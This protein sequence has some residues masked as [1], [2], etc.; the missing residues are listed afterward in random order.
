M[1]YEKAAV[2]FLAWF[3]I[4]SIGQC[5]GG[6]QS[7]DPKALLAKVFSQEILWQTGMPPGVAHADLQ[8][9][10]GKGGWVRGEYDFYWASPSQW[11]EE[12]KLGNYYRI[13]VGGERGYWQTSNLQYEPDV[14]FALDELLNVKTALKIAEHDSLTKV[15]VRRKGGV[16]EYC[17]EAKGKF[18][19]DSTI[20]FDD[21]GGELLSVD[22]PAPEVGNRSEISHIE[23]SSFKTVNGKTIPFEVQGFHGRKP[24]LDVRITK[25]EAMPEH[26]PGLFEQPPNS[27]FWASCDDMT[28]AKL[29]HMV[30]PDSPRPVEF[31]KSITLYLVVETDGSPSHIAVTDGQDPG[32]EAA[33]IRAARQWRY[34][35]SMCG[36]TPVRAELS[37]TLTVGP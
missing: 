4:P 3:L 34:K 20:C 19:T 26:D 17:S 7:V 18:R 27:E 36:N 37:T 24:T 2:L 9:V 21:P 30:F 31:T 16:S 28:E 25:I 13:R 1:F 35:P 10:D 14:V 5:R 11:R 6:K 29:I 23:Y 8:L 33:A 12:L 32:L 22:Y 15:H